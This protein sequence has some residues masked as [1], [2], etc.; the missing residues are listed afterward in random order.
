MSACAP[1][2]GQTGS[3]RSSAAL[4]SWVSAPM[5]PGLRRHRCCSCAIRVANL[6]T[7]F[8]SCKG[9]VCMH[10]AARQQCASHV[11]ACHQARICAATHSALRSV[12]GV[13]FVTEGHRHGATVSA[14]CDKVYDSLCRSKFR[15][16]T[17]PLQ[18]IPPP[19]EASSDRDA[20]VAHARAHRP[21]C[22]G[23]RQQDRHQGWHQPQDPK[24]PFCS[25]S[26]IQA[27]IRAYACCSSVVSE[28]HTRAQLAKALIF[29]W[30]CGRLW[31]TCV[32]FGQSSVSGLAVWHQS[33]LGPNTARHPSK[34]SPDCSLLPELCLSAL[35]LRRVQLSLTSFVT[36]PVFLARTLRAGHR[37]AH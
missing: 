9:L 25:A 23:V 8:V 30:S 5:L 15:L 17:C 29:A 18:S 35:A 13:E 4:H 27:I 16:L 26:L 3:A 14:S 36:L 33:R 7:L 34:S 1:A 12:L 32:E 21:A 2:G 19:R 28:A 20:S 6:Y 10:A 11:S 22:P 24:H 37:T 31:K